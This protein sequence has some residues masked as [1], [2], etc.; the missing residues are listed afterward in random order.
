MTDPVEW[1]R[2]GRLA[3]IRTSRGS[4]AAAVGFATFI[5]LVA[6]SVAVPVLPD[7]ATRLGASPTRIGLLFASFGVT[8]MAVSIPMGGI[9]DRIGRKGPMVAGLLTLSLATFLFAFARDLPWLFAARLVQG[10]ADAV[11]WVV[12]FA[13]IADLY[14]PAERGRVMGLVMAGTSFGLT[15]GPSLGGWLYE[16][17]GIT[18]PFVVVAVA[19][20]LNGLAFLLL[21]LPSPAP[22]ERHTGL[23]AVLG[24]PAVLVCT[25]AA[26]AGSGTITMLEPVLPLVFTSRLGLGPAHI[27]LLFGIASFSSM[28]V[29]PIYGSLSDRYGG[30]RLTSIGLVLS[31]CLLPLIST[32][33]SI[34][35][36]AVLMVVLWA[37]LSMTV[38]PS[39]AFIAEA[40]SGAGVES[41]GVV[42]GAYNV[43]WA[44]GMLT[45]PA[46]GGFLLER[47]GFGALS[48]VWAPILLLVMVV[49]TT[50]HTPEPR[51]AQ[52]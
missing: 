11:T 37:A 31:A 39:L 18:L 35:S 50:I 13:L 41:F 32:A 8:L 27:G 21:K 28:L 24:V 29:H 17:G 47:V 1:S 15:I 44:V 16:I 4:V 36:A 12:G 5:D 2:R 48:L 25:V 30:K 22:A 19:A 7:L 43:A 51:T 20:A 9:S 38:T 52:L 49:L 3:A 26:T 6:Y 10:A 23:R 42:Y 33:W 40:A 34:T 45:G 14:G 46:L